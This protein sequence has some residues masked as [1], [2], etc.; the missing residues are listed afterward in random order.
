MHWPPTAFDGSDKD[1]C[2]ALLESGADL[3][4]AAESAN[5]S[6]SGPVII[7]LVVAAR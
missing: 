4:E 7:K 5:L 2:P 3:K 1:G 6:A